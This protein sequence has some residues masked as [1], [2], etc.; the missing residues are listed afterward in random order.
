VSLITERRVSQLPGGCGAAV[1]ARGENWLLPGG[2]ER[3]AKR[4]PDKCTLR[5]SVGDVTRM[6]TPAGGGWGQPAG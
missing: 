5:L 6:L 1:P 2:Y 3:L 4:L